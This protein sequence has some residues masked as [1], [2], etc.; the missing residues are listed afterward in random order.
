MYPILHIKQRSQ[1]MVAGLPL[2]GHGRTLR[3]CGV[4]PGVDLPEPFANVFIK[5][6]ILNPIKRVSETFEING[7]A[8]NFVGPD[9]SPFIASA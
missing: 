1:C 6:E 5:L 8:R 2:V 3:A 9:E 4:T 7:T